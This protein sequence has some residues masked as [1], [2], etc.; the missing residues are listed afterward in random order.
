MNSTIS[1]IFAF[2]A[3]AALTSANR[4]T[5][6][7]FGGPSDEGA[8]KTKDCLGWT[9][10]GEENACGKA[11]DCTLFMAYRTSRG[12]KYA[13]VEMYHSA[14]KAHEGWI[15]VGFSEDRKMGNDAVVMDVTGSIY[16]SKYD[17][18]DLLTRWNVDTPDEASLETDDIGAISNM[19]ELHDG[20]VYC[21]V[22]V[23]LQF[24]IKEPIEE[25]DRMMDIDLTKGYHLMMAAGDMDESGNEPLKH[26]QAAASQNVIKIGD[27]SSSAAVIVQPLVMA[28]VFVLASIA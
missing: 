4:Y 1:V 16:M 12:G 25:G 21:I 15:A 14:D 2:L 24:T 17:P 18:G 5:G 10:G 23:P 19:T 9:E 27:T 3:L 7:G 11:E 20:M 8:E 6:C 26:R 22:E 28:L 13:Y